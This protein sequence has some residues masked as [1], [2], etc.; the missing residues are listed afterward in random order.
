MPPG[1]QQT[2]FG[3][4]ARGD[5]ADHIA[6]HNRFRP[7]LARLGRIFKLF[8]NRH[9]ESFADQGQQIA[10]GGMHRHATHRD[11][12]A[13]MLAAPGQRNIQRPACGNG[14]VKEHFVEIAHPI[15]QQRARIGR[16]DLQILRHHRR[17]AV[18]AHL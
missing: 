5:Q 12:F 1:I 11:I 18:F 10:F 4:G 13:Q 9:P 3:Q 6:P 15:E 7:A 14:I 17:D 8:R 2:F 16:L